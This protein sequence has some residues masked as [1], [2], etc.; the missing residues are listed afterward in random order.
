MNSFVV[1]TIIALV[2][3]LACGLVTI[4]LVLDFCKRKGLYDMPNIRKVH[5]RAIPR[6]GGVVFLPCVLIGCVVAFMMAHW[7]GVSRIE[8]SLWSIYFLVGTGAIYMTGLIDD[9]VGL[10]ALNK[11]VVP[12]FAALAFPLS[13]LWLN[14]LYGL[15]GI[16]QL[17]WWV[18]SLLTVGMVVFISNAINLIDGIDGLAGSLSV[19]AMTGFLLAFAHDGMWYFVVLIASMIGVVLA[20]L[21]YNIWGDADRNRKIF[22][23]DTGS[24]S[25]GFILAFLCL[26]LTVRTQNVNIHY[27]EEKVLLAFTLIIIPVFDSFRV[28]VVRLW[29]RRSP[30]LPDKNH[31]HHKLLRAGLSHHRALI[32]V[33]LLALGF[34]GAN[35]LLHFFVGASV[36]IVV[37]VVI[38][39]LFHT[40]LNRFIV[41]KGEKAIVF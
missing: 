41:S 22:M 30:I 4:P 15:F 11:L 26:K 1:L 12:I 5:K 36:I 10:K 18:G 17:S 13:G 34:V 23:G 20:Y 39:A 7:Q 9:L 21:Y 27:D 33:L 25:I 19:L 28:A 37:D 29:H 24:L 8:L 32:V 35:Y 6:L 2:A 31:I 3:S 38:Y 16:H 14:D 40:V